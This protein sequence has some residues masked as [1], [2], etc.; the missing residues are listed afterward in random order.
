MV[1]AFV[2]VAH[3]SV[4]RKTAI[5]ISPAFLKCPIV[6]SHIALLIRDEEGIVAHHILIF[7]VGWHSQEEL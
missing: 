6:I 3:I 5:G 1:V 7:L 4:K 2:Q